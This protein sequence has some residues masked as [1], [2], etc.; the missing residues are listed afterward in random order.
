MRTVTLVFSMISYATTGAAFAQGPIA[1]RDAQQVLPTKVASY[2]VRA[3]NLL[4][5]VAQ[6]SSDFNLPIGVE[7]AGDRATAKEIVREWHNTTVDQ[8][9]RDVASFDVEYQ[10]ELSNGVVHV[11][12]F[13]IT[14]NS[15]NPLN[16]TI[17]SFKTE[18]IY[19]GDAAFQLS[20]QASLL[21]FPRQEAQ[22]SACGGSSSAGSGE[23]RLSLAMTDTTVR[24][25]LD[26]LLTRS[27]F[28]MWV[29][30]FPNQQ[31]DT[32]YLKTESL[33]G[34]KTDPQQP[35][36]S[37]VARYLDP[38]TGRHRGDWEIRLRK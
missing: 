14:D 19:T 22:R 33:W 21:M 2:S 24:D 26:A 5:A 9:L 37:F 8:I 3:K 12:K 35:D 25:I 28:A 11:R 4:Q 6:V 1:P 38:L 10:L 20:K 31:P 13:G 36:L 32:G 7:W 18:G 27:E 30:V 16:I 15:R 29:V 23:K 17:P 34:N